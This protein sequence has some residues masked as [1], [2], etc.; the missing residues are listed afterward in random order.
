MQTGEYTAKIT[1]GTFVAVYNQIPGK[2]IAFF[3][4]VKVSVSVLGNNDIGIPTA[5]L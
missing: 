2:V 3:C 5:I 4:G 1:H